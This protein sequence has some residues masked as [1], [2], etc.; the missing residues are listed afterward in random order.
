MN[1]YLIKEKLPFVHL[2]LL[3]KYEFI[4]GKKNKKKIKLIK[5]KRVLVLGNNKFFGESAM[6]QNELR[7]TTI[8][9]LEN[10][11]LGYLCANLY[12]T[13]FLFYINQLYKIKLIF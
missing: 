6:R 9:V 7:N 4:I 12:T 11:Y 3:S 8:R 5:Y 1:N 10:S 2:Y 13:N